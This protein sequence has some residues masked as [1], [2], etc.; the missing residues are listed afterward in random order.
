MS[1][2]MITM[3]GLADVTRIHRGSVAG[4]ESEALRPGRSA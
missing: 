3:S 1:P 2:S 4:E